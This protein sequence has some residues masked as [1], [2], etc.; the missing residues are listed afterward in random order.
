GAAE[1]GGPPASA[2][3]SESIARVRRVDHL[4]DLLERDERATVDEA[5]DDDR[6]DDDEHRQE[7]EEPGA[8]GRELL[9]LRVL[10]AKRAPMFRDPAVERRDDLARPGTIACEDGGGELRKSRERPRLELRLR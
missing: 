8:T 2:R 9:E 3:T 1:I 6:C 4:Q 5:S 7:D 10:L